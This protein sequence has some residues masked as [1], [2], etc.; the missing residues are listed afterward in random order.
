M[1][2]SKNKNII[3]ESVNQK[4]FSLKQLET[5]E[6][7]FSWSDDFNID[8]WIIKWWALKYEYIS[9]SIITSSWIINNS[10]SFIWEFKNSTNTWSLLFENL[11]WYINFWI[12]TEIPFVLSEKKYRIETKIWNNSFNET[13]NAK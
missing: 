3:F 1:E 7:S 9:D 8:I 5:L 12:N 11:W 6:L 13:K 10:E 2:L 4:N